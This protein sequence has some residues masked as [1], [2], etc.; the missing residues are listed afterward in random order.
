MPGATV[1]R[2]PNRR[3][4]RAKLLSA[5][6]AA[7]LSWQTLHL[8]RADDSTEGAE[9][10]IVAIE[11]VAVVDVMQG[12]IVSPRTVLIVDG[13]IAAIGEPGAVALPPAAVRVDGREHYLIPGLVDMH[14]HLFNNATHRP[15]NDWTFPLF[16]AS[17]VTAVREMCAVPAPAGSA[18]GSPRNLSNRETMG[19]GTGCRQAVAERRPAQSSMVNRA[20][21]CNT[22]V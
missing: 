10:P 16:V 4:V 13:R 22:P 6:A 15:P 12:R 1:N 5:T 19:K 21:V 2:N 11:S 9:R 20:C 14:V 8:C 17:G 18:F 3:V 7:L